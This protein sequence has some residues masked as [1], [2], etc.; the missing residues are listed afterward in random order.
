MS[1]ATGTSRC[2]EMVDASRVPVSFVL[3]VVDQGGVCLL[4]QWT[5]KYG[6]LLASDGCQLYF[7]PLHDALQTDTCQFLWV[8]HHL[9]DKRLK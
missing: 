7:T 1:S 6:W 8:R 5:G 3:A 2:L 9:A 4:A